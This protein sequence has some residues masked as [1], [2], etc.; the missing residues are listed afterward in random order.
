[1]ND[2]PLDVVCAPSV[3]LPDLDVQQQVIRSSVAIEN[4]LQP[5]RLWERML[6]PTNRPLPLPEKEK[7]QI[8]V[9]LEKNKT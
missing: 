8:S 3:S 9:I 6:M 5:A 7:L 2:R 4:D 1:M